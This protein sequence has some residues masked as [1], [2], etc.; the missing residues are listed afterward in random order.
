MS[1]TLKK[2]RTHYESDENGHY[3]KKR[4]STFNNKKLRS[5][6]NVLKTKDVKRILNYEDKI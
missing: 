6:D 4:K 1:K 3:V 2:F 5:L